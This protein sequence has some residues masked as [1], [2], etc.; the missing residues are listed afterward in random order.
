MTKG[1]HSLNLLVKLMVLHNFDNA[2]IAETILMRISAKQVPSLHRVVPLY[3][4]LFT[5]SN[6]RPFMLISAGGHDLSF[7]TPLLCLRVY[8]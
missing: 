2:A 1:L 7:H 4:K 5:S 3:L 6:N 8:W